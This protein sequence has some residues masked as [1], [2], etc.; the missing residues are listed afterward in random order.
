MAESKSNPSLGLSL[1]VRGRGAVDNPTGRFEK[2]Q[3]ALDPETYEELRQAGHADPDAQIPTQAFHDTSRS[4]IA[5]NDSPDIGMEATLNPYR[6]CEH[7]CIYCYARPT[8]EYLGLSAGLD[9]E[10]KIFVKPD[11][12]RL[13]EE[14]L[15]SHAWTPKVVTM[16]GVTDCYQPL[17]RTLKITRACLQVLLDFRNPA[18]IITKNYLVT[19]DTDILKS[20]ADRDL[21]GVNLSITTL[22]KDLCRAMEPRASPPQRRLAAIEAL[23]KA[24]VPVRVMLGPVLPGLTEH[25]IPAILKS[26]ADAGA[27]GAGYTML[28]LPHGVKDLFQTWLAENYPDRAQKVLNRVREVRSGKLNDSR[29][30]SRMRGEGIYAE[31][32]GKMFALYRKRYGLDRPFKPLSVVGFR[33]EARGSQFGLFD[34]L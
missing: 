11:A 10:S 31:Q 33:R 25:E 21:I 3:T 23:A 18:V 27:Q 13:L 4:I 8:H 6:G 7:G 17:E 32:I 9:F 15:R 28:R 2:I 19:R 22:D 26:A 16:S 30:G 29:F 14:K 1:P 12:P 24:G 5:T 34:E 20:M